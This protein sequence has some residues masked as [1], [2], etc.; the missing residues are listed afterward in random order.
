MRPSCARFCIAG[1]TNACKPDKPYP[2]NPNTFR[3]R[4]CDYVRIRMRGYVLYET[5]LRA[6]R[7]RPA[8]RFALRDCAH[9]DRMRAYVVLDSC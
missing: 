2:L 7:E 1:P 5:A 9:Q 4:T 6:L 3:M 8:E